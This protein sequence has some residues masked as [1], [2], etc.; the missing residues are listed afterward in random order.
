MKYGAGLGKMRRKAKKRPVN[1][2]DRPYLLHQK[3]IR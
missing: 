3:I 1:N 2:A